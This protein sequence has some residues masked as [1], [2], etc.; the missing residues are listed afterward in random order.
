MSGI[1][2]RMHGINDESIPPTCCVSCEDLSEVGV[3]ALTSYCSFSCDP[4]EGLVSQFL[5]FDIPNIHGL[6]HAQ[7]KCF[8]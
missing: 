1:E 3:L 6:T 8:R 2:F 4:Q 5:P 7:P